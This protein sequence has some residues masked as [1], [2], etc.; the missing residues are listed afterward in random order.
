M[1]S[2]FL[3]EAPTTPWWTA[4]QAKTYL[5]FAY[6]TQDEV[7]EGQIR[8]AEDLVEAYLERGLRTQTWRIETQVGLGRW[9][10]YGV[11][12]SESHADFF[13]RNLIAWRP[14][15][16][17]GAAGRTSGGPLRCSRFAR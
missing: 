3:L 9:G 14:G 15:D 5:Q 6:D 2:A 7:I 16:C 12:S 13:V 4:A 17:S 11:E 8:A 1:A 10:G